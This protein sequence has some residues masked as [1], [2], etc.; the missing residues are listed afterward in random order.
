MLAVFRVV[1]F[2]SLKGNDLR[3][4]AVDVFVESI[5]GNRSFPA[6]TLSGRFDEVHVVHAKRHRA[7][8]DV[9]A[10]EKDIVFRVNFGDRLRLHDDS[11][12]TKVV[13]LVEATKVFLEGF[14]LGFGVG[15][16]VEEESETKGRDVIGAG[17][18][19]CNLSS[20][21]AD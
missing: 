11:T 15:K 21:K 9:N 5:L 2:D 1:V 6:D 3:D 14:D 12:F 7:K 4:F 16:L 20:V 17:A 19:G 10:L 13:G 8:D 18:G